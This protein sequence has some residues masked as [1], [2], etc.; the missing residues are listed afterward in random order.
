MTD[1]TSALLN[2]A[3]KRL[4][5]YQHMDEHQKSQIVRPRGGIEIDYSVNIRLMEIVISSLSDKPQLSHR[6]FN[7]LLDGLVETANTY[8]NTTELRKEIESR[9]LKTITTNNV[10]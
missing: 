2:I 8:S 7:D 4:R 10:L 9:L 3:Y 1:E 6:S 5:Q